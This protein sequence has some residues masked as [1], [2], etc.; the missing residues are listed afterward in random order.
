MQNA[1]SVP[2]WTYKSALYAAQDEESEKSLMREMRCREGNVEHILCE[3]L[4]LEKIG[5]Q[6]LG[7]ARMDPD[8]IKE[9]RLSSTVALDKGAGWLNSTL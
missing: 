7:F 3:F 4:V 2:N 5:M 8:Q 9:A 6:T 1:G